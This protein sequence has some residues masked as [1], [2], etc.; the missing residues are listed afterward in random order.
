MIVIDTLSRCIPGAD[1][2][3]WR[4]IGEIHLFCTK[5]H[6]LENVAV[7]FIYH[8]PKGDPSGAGTGAGVLLN[9]ADT[10]I[11]LECKNINNN[12][13]FNIEVR[14]TKQRDDALTK[15]NLTAYPVPVFNELGGTFQ[16]EIKS[17]HKTL[18][19]KK[20]DA[21]DKAK[22]SELGGEISKWLAKNPNSI[23]SKIASGVH[24]NINKVREEL[25]TLLNQNVIIKIEKNRR[26]EFSVISLDDSESS[27][28]KSA[29][30]TP[31]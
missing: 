27:V 10:E 28:E 9:A 24:K 15:L 11:R 29:E 4:D 14:T 5:L 7:V 3:S 20:T 22:I 13:S 30:E 2:N 8:P 23:A 19:L 18:L 26:H 31:F 16:C 25:D 17:E 1:P 12:G 6:L 21:K